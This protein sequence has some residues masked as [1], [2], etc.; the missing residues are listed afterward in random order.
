MAM[1]KRI[2]SIFVLGFIITI[3]LLS[4]IIFVNKTLDKE[5]EKVIDTQIEE[6]INGFNQMQ[7]L[8]G[9]GDTYGNRMT[10]LIF[11]NMLQDLDK[12]IWELGQKI[13]KYRQTSE[14]FFKSP[15]YRQQKKF[16]NEKEV[17]YLNLLRGV[18]QKCGFNQPIILFF[19]RNSEDC[20]KCDDQSFVL[21]DINE[22]IDEE[23]SIFSFDIDMNLTTLKILNQYYEI[24][25]YPCLVIDDKRYCGMQDKNIIMKNLCMIA[26]ISV[27][28]EY[29]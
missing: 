13:D 24:D 22:K 28:P 8:L 10:C 21:S 11:E 18:K 7:T 17:F 5:R 20:K 3:V 23:I 4:I 9:M 27:C 14:E 25:E 1:K 16:F 2:K 15:Y 26:N 29:G 19:Y 6:V 12:S